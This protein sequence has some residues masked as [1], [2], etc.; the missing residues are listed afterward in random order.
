M[1]THLD[2][3]SS[4]VKALFSFLKQDSTIRVREE[5]RAHVSEQCEIASKYSFLKPL[6]IANQANPIFVTILR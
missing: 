5:I 2:V 3:L 4:T 1:F 6:V